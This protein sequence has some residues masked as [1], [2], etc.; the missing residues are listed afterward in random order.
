MLLLTSV[1]GVVED[2][3]LLPSTTRTAAASDVGGEDFSAGSQRT[4]LFGTCRE[5]AK[6]WEAGTRRPCVG[7][8]GAVLGNDWPSCNVSHIFA[9]CTLYSFLGR[10]SSALLTM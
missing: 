3:E 5:D 10:V 4:P 9:T 2:E 8:I 7:T 6:H 1:R